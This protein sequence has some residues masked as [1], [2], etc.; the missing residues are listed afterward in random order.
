VPGSNNVGYSGAAGKGYFTELVG[1]QPS[2][3]LLAQFT[4]SVGDPGVS[5]LSDSVWNFTSYFYNFGQTGATTPS[6]PLPTSYNIQKTANITVLIQD[7][8]NTV[9]LGTSKNFYSIGEFDAPSI[10]PVGISAYSIANPS[11]AH[12]IIKYILQS[13]TSAGTVTQLWTQGDYVSEVI[14]SLTPPQG[15]TGPG[16]TGPKGS[17]GSTGSIGPTGISGQVGPA[18]PAGPQGNQGNGFIFTVQNI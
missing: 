3:T 11:T 1:A 14:T 16:Y 8:A 6:T 15:P 12:L 4:S 13:T 2:G 7:G 9:T 17:T 18:G 10:V 5:T